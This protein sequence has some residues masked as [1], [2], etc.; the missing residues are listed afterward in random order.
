[1]SD[2]TRLI[3]SQNL[4]KLRIDKKLS[5]KDAAEF[6]NLPV[7]TYQKYEQDAAFPP[8]ETLTLIAEKYGVPVSEL[9]ATGTPAIVEELKQKLK[10]AKMRVAML[11]FYSTLDKKTELPVVFEAIRNIAKKNGDAVGDDLLQMSPEELRY[12][13]WK[14]AT[15]LFDEVD[16]T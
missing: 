2:P 14:T 9:F 3:L 4:R 5:Q 7:H 15:K 12:Q 1:M 16:L 13:S 11:Y 8:P 10:V 6:L